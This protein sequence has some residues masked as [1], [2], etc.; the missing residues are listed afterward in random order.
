MASTTAQEPALRPAR[1]PA[2]KEA[3]L[4]RQLAEYGSAMVALSAGVDST[5]LLAVAHEALGGA[6]TAVTADSPSLA[7]AS[8]AEA[9][10]F[11][12]ERGIRHVVIA[13]DEFERAD[14]L[15]NDGQRCFHCKAALMRAMDGLAAATKDGRGTQALLL[16]AIV[17]DLADHRPGMR[18]AAEAGARWPL[19]DC[20]FT[21]EDVRQRSRERALP[22]WNRPAEPCLSSRVP[23]GEPVSPEAVRMIEAAETLLRSHGLRECRA[24][25]HQVG[26][27]ADGKPRGHLC[28]I[29]VPERDLERVVAVRSALVPALRALGYL[30]VTLDLAGLASG[31]F[32]A[33]LGPTGRGVGT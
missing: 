6:V 12:R 9:E 2:E 22:T 8:L 18:A 30:N 33:L 25:H 31:G 20:G 1:N 7:R 28:R 5:Y 19:A 29:E 15:A 17:D 24:R 14:Y 27:G 4:L 21:K 26:R 16:G 3:A 10:A 23:Y 11:C 32:N 13:T